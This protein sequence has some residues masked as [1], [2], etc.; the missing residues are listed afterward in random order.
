MVILTIV[1]VTVLGS[2]DRAV[3]D[4]WLTALKQQQEII[5]ISEIGIAKARGS[6]AANLAIT[7]NLSFSSSKGSLTSLASKAGV[8]ADAKLLNTGK[9]EQTDLRLTQAEQTNQF[10]EIFIQTMKAQLADYQATIKK[11]HEASKTKTAKDQLNDSYQDAGL[12]IASQ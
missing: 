9:D 11:L 12:L 10:D 3:K 8:K 7:T 4:D 5:R 1:V 6:E 2:V